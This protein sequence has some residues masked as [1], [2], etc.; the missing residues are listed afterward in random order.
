MIALSPTRSI[1][2]PLC[3]VRERFNRFISHFEEIPTL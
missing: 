3:I 2:P 1:L